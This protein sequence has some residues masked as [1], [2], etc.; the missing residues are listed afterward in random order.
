ASMV[1]KV[2]Q[3]T[4]QDTLAW[5]ASADQDVL[6]APFK[7]EYVFQLARFDNPDPYGSDSFGLAVLKGRRALMSFN[8]NKFSR[9]H[10]LQKAL[11]EPQSKITSVQYFAELWKRAFYRAN[12][13]PEEFER[14]N[15]LLDSELN[16]MAASQ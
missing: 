16:Q 3:L 14:V 7:G 6:I 9:T 4:R 8:S 5:E 13:I 2:L 11:D 15:K 10:D 12:R 1:A